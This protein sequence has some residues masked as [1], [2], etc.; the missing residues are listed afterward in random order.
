MELF[1]K[2]NQLAE[3]FKDWIMVH[4][5]DPMLWIGLFLVIAVFMILGYSTLDKG[6]R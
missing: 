3:K 2:L 4:Y 1:N 6:K 5:D